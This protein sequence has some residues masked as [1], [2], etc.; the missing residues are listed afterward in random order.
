MNTPIGSFLQPFLQ[1][2]GCLSRLALACLAAPLAAAGE[3]PTGFK[4]VSGSITQD[5][6]TPGALNLQQNSERAIVNWNSFSIGQDNAVN[7]SQPGRSSMLLNRVQGGLPS[8]I[9]GRL[10]ANGRVFLVNPNGVV[11]GSGAQV[12]TGGLVASTLD[13]ADDDFNAGR[14]KFSR[15]DGNQAAVINRGALQA[16][17]GGTVALLGAVV[18]NEGTIKADGGTAALVS[19]RQLSLDF[20]GDGLT[21]FRIDA[22]KPASQALVENAAGGV[23]QADGGRVAILADPATAAQLVVNQQGVL[24]ARSLEQ[25]AG[26]I[27]LGVGAD[28]RAEV[29]GRLDASGGPGL[30][31]GTVAIGGGGLYLNERA[32]VDAGGG[33][34]GGRIEVRAS[35]S[36]ALAAG[37]RLN[38]DARDNGKG[39]TLNLQGGDSLRAHGS[40]Q[41]RGAGQG[42]GGFVETS[43]RALDLTGVQVDTA[44]APGQPA[45]SWL[46]DPFNITV[47]P[48]CDTGESSDPVLDSPFDPVV[49]DSIVFDSAISAALDAGSNVRI[50]TG[51]AAAGEIGGDIVIGD[52]VSILRQEATGGALELRFDANQSISGG[53]FSIASTAAPLNLVFNANANGF[54]P[55]AGFIRFVGNVEVASRLRTQ[56]GSVHF[57]G[58][59]NPDNGTASNA[60]GSG[61]LIDGMEIDTRDATLGGSGAVVMRGRADVSFS[62]EDAPDAGVKLQNARIDAADGR[63]LVQ[64][65]VAGTGSFGLYGALVG[66][67][68]IATRGGAIEFDG[69]ALPGGNGGLQVSGSSLASQSGNIRLAGQGQASDFGLAIFQSTLS[70]SAGTVE[71]DG[72]TAAGTVGAV[73]SASQIGSGSGD[74]LIRGRTGSGQ[75]G[76]LLASSDVGADSGDLTLIGLAGQADA[77]PAA[78]IGLAVA[79]GSLVAGQGD[80]DLRGRVAAASE[81]DGS[82]SAGLLFGFG[83][84]GSGEVRADAGNVSL[85]GE[86]AEGSSVAGLRFVDSGASVFAGDE[87][88]IR[89][90]SSDP[91]QPAL[92][93]AAASALGGAALVNL[94][95][96]GVAA[97]GSLTDHFATPI[98]IGVDPV[99]GGLSVSN[100][101]ID[102]TLIDRLSPTP[103]LALGSDGQAGSIVVVG[104]PSFAESTLG[105]LTLQAEGSGGAIDLRAPLSL[106]G[107]GLALLAD[108]PLTQQDGA[109]LTAA[110]LVASS[111]SDSVQLAAANGV[112]A[113]AGR[114]AGAFR[115]HNAVGDLRL[116]ELTFTAMSGEV[117]GERSQA[118]VQAGTILVL[119]AE[120]GNLT[121][122][123]SASLAAASLLATSSSGVLLDNPDNETGS[124][125]GLAGQSFSYRDAT[126][127]VLGG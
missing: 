119:N 2:A 69:T 114:A 31:G 81:T 120:G 72:T 49:A 82:S 53:F 25:R 84:I 42:A 80:I 127:I 124:L 76:L 13:I 15:A 6:G 55:E 56:G 40:L 91:A 32:E 75:F 8:E 4:P 27:V 102:Q 67:S 1:R 107:G 90:A 93:V 24:R 28:D 122:D 108:G 99:E 110:R 17:P 92:D 50:H 100:F 74:T 34:G 33:A 10:T 47:L 57:I 41:A 46:I 38:A 65:R 89:A 3:L 123:S 54:R 45:G 16:G 60:F 58:Q 37:S 70:T 64:G 18:R 9:A 20:E 11:F 26:E 59:S 105:E 61:I 95:P 63:V 106:P 115:F 68:E 94:R 44:G 103:R 43:A 126:G 62:S 101:L 83:E 118:G 112:G 71:L 5:L 39:G 66:Q 87:L 48:C 85:A 79:G 19:A 52:G 36:A 7:I 88:L 111:R 21:T 113:L 77:A 116:A 51:P 121:Q 86:A 30:Q 117:G 29:A 35:R 14:L 97:D 12:S 73:V 78:R 109:P 22:D 98:Q 96:G 104:S 125:A 23:V